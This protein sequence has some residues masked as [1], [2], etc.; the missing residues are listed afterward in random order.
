MTVTHQREL[1]TFLGSR[2]VSYNVCLSKALGSINASIFL[3]QL[4]YWSG[5]SRNPNWIYKTVEEM[6]EETG[7]TKAEQLTAQK[8]LD[9]LGIIEV[10][11][12]GIPRIRR[13]RINEKRLYEVCGEFVD[14]QRKADNQSAEKPPI[15]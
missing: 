15:E 9:S 10:K 2:L 12:K 11:R 5:K 13:F 14:K 6:R 3:N 1:A 8:L 4:L 7:L